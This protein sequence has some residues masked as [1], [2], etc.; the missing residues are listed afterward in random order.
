[1]KSKEEFVEELRN[2]LEKLNSIYIERNEDCLRLQKEN[3]I[4]RKNYDG[5]L[6]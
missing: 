4:Y 6:E 2:D 1:V 3:E 5:F